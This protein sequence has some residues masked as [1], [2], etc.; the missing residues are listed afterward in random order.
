MTDFVTHYEILMKD[1]DTKEIVTTRIEPHYTFNEAK[2]RIRAAV[3]R[4][5]N[6]NVVWAGIRSQ[7]GARVIL[8]GDKVDGTWD[9]TEPKIDEQPENDTLL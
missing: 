8:R 9:W 4:T 2:K 7:P 5:K 6:G 3:T 1:G